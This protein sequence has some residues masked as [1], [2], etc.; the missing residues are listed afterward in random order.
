MGRCHRLIGLRGGNLVAIRCVMS[1]SIFSKDQLCRHDFIDLKRFLRLTLGGH[2]IA[3][4]NLGANTFYRGVICRERPEV[5]S[6]ILSASA[7]RTA[8]RHGACL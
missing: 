1:G 5:V 2:G 8:S 7:Q 4:K 6:R 3:V